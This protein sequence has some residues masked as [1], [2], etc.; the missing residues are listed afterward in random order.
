MKACYWSLLTLCIS[1]SLSMP[2]LGGEI[3]LN[4][5][6]WI[7]GD[8]KRLQDDTIYWQSENFGELTIKK[9]KVLQLRTDTYMK[10]NGHQLPCRVRGMDEGQ[11]MYDCAD[12]DKVKL[13]LLSVDSLQP[14][15]EY[16]A[17]AYDYEG[18][19]AIAG[20]HSRGNKV[21]EDWD[22][23]SKVMFRRGEY[24]HVMTL[25][26]ESESSDD[27]PVDEEYD[28]E[29]RL[30]WFFE[31]NWFWYNEVG[32]GADDSKNIDE[33]YL[34]GTGLGHQLWET[35]RSTLA[36]ELGVEYIKELFNPTEEQEL[37]PSFDSKLD[38]T[39][40]RF[41]TD[42]KYQFPWSLKFIHNHELLYSLDNSDDWRFSSDTGFNVP[43]GKGLFSEFL[44]EYDY[45]NDPQAD[46][47]REDTKFKVGVGYEW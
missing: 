35:H 43:L 27:D 47:R 20:T 2:S 29:Y 18:K 12:G 45:D 42:Y 33:S 21:E 7:K 15:A 5:G 36:F 25:D 22:V 11:L 9:S 23:S 38:Q 46:N 10:V 39:L 30:D 13:S 31:E 24:R 34:F 32:I 26:Y 6:D 8:L 17:G 19:V 40:L 14:Y 37:D 3:I 4:N 41:A 28:V 1:I 16:A 44:F